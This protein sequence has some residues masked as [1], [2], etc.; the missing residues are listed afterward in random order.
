MAGLKVYTVQLCDAFV[1]RE[2]TAALGMAAHQRQA[3]VLIVASTK[4]AGAEVARP[5]MGFVAPGDLRVATGNDVDAMQ[6]AGVFDRP[7]LYARRAH[8]TGPVVAVDDSGP[9]VVGRLEDSA[10]SLTYVPA[11]AS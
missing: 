5:G 2:I 11:V 3:R 6:A 4:A 10:G 8:G 9:E 1:R 7:R